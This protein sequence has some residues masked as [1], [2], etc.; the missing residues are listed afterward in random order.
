LKELFSSLITMLLQVACVLLVSRARS[1]DCD[2][3]EY[4]D[5]IADVDNTLND[6]LGI[7]ENAARYFDL[8]NSMQVVRRADDESDDDNT[9]V[10]LE[11]CVSILAA[12]D[13]YREN[14]M[15][16]A[17]YQDLLRMEEKV[18]LHELLKPLSKKVGN[19]IYVA[20]MDGDEISD[21]LAAYD[22]ESPTLVIVESVNGTVFGGYTDKI[23]T[24]SKTWQ[25]SSN[26]FV[27]QLRPSFDQ[28][29]IISTSVA[30][31]V[32]DSHL[33]FGNAI[34]LKDHALSNAL[35]WVSPS[36]YDL[37]GYELNDGE[38]YFQAKEWVVVEVE[39]L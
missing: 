20:S 19:L 18:Y 38:R 27:F 36:H 29:A 1:V 9:D 25:S 35:S 32:S 12:V 33:Q 26:A 5:L 34:N 2:G 31:H 15:R 10:K 13:T 3:F 4:D 21:F 14:H 17:R 8:V 28:H 6:C 16:H 11:A 24:T 23:W 7:M 37:D 39:D 22:N 30:T